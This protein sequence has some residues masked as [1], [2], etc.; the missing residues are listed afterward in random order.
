MTGM[1]GPANAANNYAGTLPRLQHRPRAGGGRRRPHPAGTGLTIA[2]TSTTGSSRLG[3]SWL[4]D[5][6]TNWCYSITGASPVTVPYASFNTK[7]YDASGR[8]YAKNPIHAIELPIAGAAT[9]EPVNVTLTS[10][11]EN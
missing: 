10:V 1:V 11:T 4:T 7:C 8:T 9:A 3:A 5:G 2:F 6:T